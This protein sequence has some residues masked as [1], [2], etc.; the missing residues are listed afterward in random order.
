MFRHAQLNNEDIVVGISEL[1]DKEVADNMI[2]IND[3]DVKFGSV[4][5][6][7]TGEFILPEIQTEYETQPTVEEMQA[8]MLLNIEY[9]VSRSELGLGGK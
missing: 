6:R 8:Q 9:L 1:N 3:L 4:Y 2:L 5:N 7:A